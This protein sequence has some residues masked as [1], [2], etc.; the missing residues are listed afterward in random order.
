[1]YIYIYIYVFA[2]LMYP[3]FVLSLKPCR[4]V[5]LSLQTFPIFTILGRT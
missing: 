4:I 1:M 2:P 5:V 3:R